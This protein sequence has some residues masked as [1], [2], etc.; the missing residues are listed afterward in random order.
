MKPI[1]IMFLLFLGVYSL[2]QIQSTMGAYYIKYY[3][4]REDLISIF[5]ML[6]MLP[7][8]FGVPCVPALTRKI[9][10]RGTV[11][12]GLSIAAI[13][14]ILLYLMPRDAIVGMMISRSITSF[15]YGILMGILWS[16]ITDPVEYVDWKTGKRYTAIC[17]TI[18]GLGI[19]FGM[20][21]GGALPNAILEKTGYIANQ[22]QN[23]QVI[24]AIKNL[25]A[26][27]PLCIILA[28]F[29]IFGLFYHLNEEKI[30]EMQKEIA[31]R[32]LNIN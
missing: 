29:I 30:E 2:S 23:I 5:S 20:V 3:A 8:V 22:E 28:S 13:G 15:G 24:A 32:N 12:I 14:A 16:I 21:I 9:K 25:T 10:K 17:M 7:S 31:I 1:F 26:L 18:I 4:H 27:L 19:K 6:M 11:F